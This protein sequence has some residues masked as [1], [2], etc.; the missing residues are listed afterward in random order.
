MYVYGVYKGLISPESGWTSSVYRKRKIACPPHSHSLQRAAEGRPLG[1]H[2]L[3]MYV[4][5]Y[6]SMYECMYECMYYVKIILE[7]Q[8]YVCKYV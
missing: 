6:V 7:E 5:M 4:C 3:H 8:M 1:L 2:A